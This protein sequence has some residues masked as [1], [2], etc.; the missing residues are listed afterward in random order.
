MFRSEFLSECSAS[1]L[2][3]DVEE[4][5]VAGIHAGLQGQLHLTVGG[6]DVTDT[7]DGSVTPRVGLDGP[8]MCNSSGNLRGTEGEA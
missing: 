6:C 4:P 7:H 5:G 1:A 3:L 2:A 8:H